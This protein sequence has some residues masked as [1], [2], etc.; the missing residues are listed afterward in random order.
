MKIPG[1]NNIKKTKDHMVRRAAPIDAHSFTNLIPR[2]AYIGKQLCYFVAPAKLPSTS[3]R[4][5]ETQ[6]NA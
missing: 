6:H 4:A 3:A 2:C 5:S 1:T